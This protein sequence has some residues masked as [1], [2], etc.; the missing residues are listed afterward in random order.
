MF[1]KERNEVIIDPEVLEGLYDKYEE[2]KVVNEW[3][4]HEQFIEIGD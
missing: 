1:E 4:E 3:E 2:K